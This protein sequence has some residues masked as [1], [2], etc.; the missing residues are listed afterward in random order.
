MKTTWRRSLGTLALILVAAGCGG[1]GGGQKRTPASVTVTMSATALEYG[2]VTARATAVVRDAEGTTL[3]APVT[4]QSSDSNV[5]SV[6]ADGTVTSAAIGTALISATAAADVSG[7]VTVQVMKQPNPACVVPDAPASPGPVAGP[8]SFGVLADGFDGIPPI[9]HDTRFLVAADLDGNGT[10]DLLH[11]NSNAGGGEAAGTVFVYRN[12]GT[13][14][15][16]DATASVLPDGA[17]RIDQPSSAEVA[18]LDGDDRADIFVAQQGH[19]DQGAASLLF[20]SEPNAKLVETGGVALDPNAATSVTKATASGD[21]DCDGDVDLFQSAIGPTAVSTL[22]VNDGSGAFRGDPLRL[23][24][25]LTSGNVS[26]TAAAACDVDRDGDVDLIGGG[27]NG[28]ALARDALLLNDGFGNFR[29]APDGAL[30]PWAFSAATNV[31]VAVRCADLDQDG[32]P[33]LVVSRTDAF[34]RGAVTL[35]RNQQDRSFATIPAEGLEWPSGWASSVWAADFNADGWPDLS[36]SGVGGDHRGRV[37]ANDGDLTFTAVT[38]PRDD[39]PLTPI[40]ANGDGRAD[41]VAPETAG[42]PTLMVNGLDEE[43][44]PPAHYFRTDA[45]GDRLEIPLG[46]ESA[47][48]GHFHFEARGFV[49]DFKPRYS[50]GTLLIYFW[51]YSGNN[52]YYKGAGEGFLYIPSQYAMTNYTCNYGKV[53]GRSN[54]PGE[55]PIEAC[56]QYDAWQS[57]KWYVFDIYWDGQSISIYIDGEHKNTG[58][59]GSNS[60]PLIAGFGFPPADVEE[61]GILGMEFQNWSFTAE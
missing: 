28:S 38:P 27:W 14:H 5:A 50:P 20:S 39:Q 24:S 25:A 8:P 58:F 48:R 21:L 18:D 57:Q 59:Y 4:W 29:L 16:Q 60:L 26:F 30:P 34:T 56:Y 3:S 9:P 54:T 61:E 42:S 47:A 10:R 15:F 19:A 53:R 51:L 46:A 37:L 22:Y 31:T 41:L 33:D 2:G 49:D 17:T 23:P 40:D 1:D 7:S 52:F 45:P 55:W 12:D 6:A 13:G 44:P 11:L 36:V 32:F 35:L 43:P